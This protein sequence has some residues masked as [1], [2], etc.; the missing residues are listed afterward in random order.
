MYVYVYVCM[1]MCIC[2]Y[3]YMCVCVYVCMCICV[4]VCICVHGCSVATASNWAA[5]LLV[6][7]TFLSLAEVN[8][9][10]PWLVYLCCTALALAFVAVLM[11]ETR[12]CSLEQV[13]L[14]LRHHS[15]SSFSLGRL[16]LELTGRP[17]P[18]P[19]SPRYSLAPQPPHHS[20]DHLDHSD[21]HLDYDHHLAVQHTV[22]EAVDQ[23]L[24]EERLEEEEEEEEEG[25][26]V[27]LV[28][29]ATAV[30]GVTVELLTDV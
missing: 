5:N 22:A 24:E 9:A 28:E 6:S 1:C 14:L 27:A 21:D 7:M 8:A 20:A 16:W 30:H 17:L 15:V 18:P 10:L 3:V 26:C 11:P 25:E 19:P 2:V 23:R 12:G 13:Q 29:G 4:Y